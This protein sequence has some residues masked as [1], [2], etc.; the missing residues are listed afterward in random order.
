MSPVLANV[1]KEGRDELTPEEAYQFADEQTRHYFGLS[2]EEFIK[3]A[4][5]GE[6]PHD[7]PMVLHLA[8]LTGARLHSC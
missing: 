2:V 5:A 6:L 1:A 3:H 7:D 8:L 4:E